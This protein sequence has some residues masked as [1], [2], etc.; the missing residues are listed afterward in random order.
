M[1][2][3]KEAPFNGASFF[4]SLLELKSKDWVFLVFSENDRTENLTCINPYKNVEAKN[5]FFAVY[6][7]EIFIY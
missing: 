5:D 2:S 6:S 7:L 1:I 4:C 3:L